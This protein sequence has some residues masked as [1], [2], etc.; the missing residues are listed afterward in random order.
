M[1]LTEEVINTLTDYPLERVRIGYRWTAVVA[2]KE[3]GRQCGLSATLPTDHTHKG[4]PAIPEAGKL[5]S[6]SGLEMAR[7]IHSEI[8]IRR[9]LG[10]AAINAL[11]E[12]H[13]QRWVDENAVEAIIRRGKGKTVALVGHFPFVH[14][15][16]EE[17]EDFYV[18]DMDPKGQD[19]PASAAPEILPRAD[20][21]AITG[22]TFINGTMGEL[23]ALCRPDAYVIIL[24]PTTP[25]SPIFHDHGVDL[26]AGSVVEDIEAVFRVLGQGAN[27]RQVHQAG[28]R[29]VL[30]SPDTR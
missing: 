7:W 20:V 18:L 19:L 25:L 22:M 29:L 9:S 30:Q 1:S 4:D 26:L 23:L 10:C 27:F 24:G 15:V 13:P 11:V 12:H 3:G 6:I 21:V 16:R 17:I 2:H 28:V 8:P 14:H 5:E